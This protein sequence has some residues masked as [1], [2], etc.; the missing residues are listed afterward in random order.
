MSLLGVNFHIVL[1]Y[2]I[3]SFWL[4][5]LSLFF[6]EEGQML[7]VWALLA[8]YLISSCSNFGYEW[9]FAKASSHAYRNKRI[10]VKIED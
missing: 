2:D 10:N 5:Q 3:F 7:I 4:D 8:K 9:V 1:D 6:H